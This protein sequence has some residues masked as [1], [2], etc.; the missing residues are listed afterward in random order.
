M[1]RKITEGAKEKGESWEIP[2][3]LVI[4]KRKEKGERRL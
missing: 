4:G 1:G 2:T 3:L